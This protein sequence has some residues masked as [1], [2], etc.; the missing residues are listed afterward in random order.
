[1]T[2]RLR[3]VFDVVLYW[4]VFKPLLRLCDFFGLMP[5]EKSEF[6]RMWIIASH[7]RF[8]SHEHN[9]DVASQLRFQAR[10]WEGSFFNI[11]RHESGPPDLGL[12]PVPEALKF[13]LR[14]KRHEP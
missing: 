3:D 2:N 11:W 10:E 9:P 14:E 13:P 7:A 1:M 8:L 6:R 4:V 12:S 5:I